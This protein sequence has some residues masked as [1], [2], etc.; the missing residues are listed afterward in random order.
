VVISKKDSY[1]GDCHAPSGRS[2]RHEDQRFPFLSAI[3]GWGN[4]DVF[5]AISPDRATGVEILHFV[6]DDP[7]GWI[8][9]CAQD[10]KK[11]LRMT[12]GI[13]GIPFHFGH[14]EAR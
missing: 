2:Q 5:L 7:R 14:P 12:R 10:D 3:L 13:L 1:L 11:K 8:L 6:Q 4:P 9:R